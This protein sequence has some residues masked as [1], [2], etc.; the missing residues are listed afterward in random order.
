MTLTK[1]L[2]SA[3][4]ILAV[5]IVSLMAASCVIATPRTQGD[6]ESKISEA[7]ALFHNGQIPKA[8]AQLRIIGDPAV[9]A[10]LELLRTDVGSHGATQF[11]LS[12]FIASVDGNRANVALLELLSD[13]SPYL[14]GLAASSLGRRK[15]KSAV[16]QLINLVNDKEVYLTT[17]VTHPYR[18]DREEPSV[19]IP[20]LVR[21]V[22]IDALRAITGKTLAGNETKDRQAAA[23][24]QWWKKQQTRN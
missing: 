8:I 1:V 12:G 4:R 6:T 10:A 3:T 20:T 17:H 22:T 5:M 24:V 7:V 23:W 2:N 9:P 21:D 13:S 16:P 15:L 19:D 11:L 14:R 18:N